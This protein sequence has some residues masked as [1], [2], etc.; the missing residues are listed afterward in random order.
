MKL[1]SHQE[2]MIF[3]H[4][5][6]NW[7]HEKGEMAP[8]HQMNQT[9]LEF[10]TREIQKHFCLTAGQGFLKGKKVLDVGCGGGLICEPLARLG[11]QVHGIDAN[12]NSIEA[13]RVHADA[14]NLEITYELGVLENISE[15][16]KYDL[17]LA[18]EVVEH[19]DNPK[20]FIASCLQ[21]LVPG[22]LFIISTL[23]RT[24]KSYLGAIF[25]AESVLKWLPKG[26]HDWYKFLKPSEIRSFLNLNGA[27]VI[28][29]SGIS[30]NILQNTWGLKEN[31][32]MNFILSAKQ[33]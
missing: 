17:V 15:T 24:Y 9:R 12:S 7:W 25:L 10:I 23:N 20:D 31:F 13:A 28:T 18:L 2:E 29:L 16:K 14:M 5:I 8:L 27:E 3:F 19:V 21:K 26:A 6:S 11:A 30:Y 32:D 22:G 4:K 1:K 33:N